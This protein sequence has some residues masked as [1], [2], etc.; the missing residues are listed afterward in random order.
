MPD[1][2]I[3]AILKVSEKAFLFRLI[4]RSCDICRP[5]CQPFYSDFVTVLLTPLAPDFD[6]IC[7]ETLA[8]SAVLWP[9]VYEAYNGS[10]PLR[11]VD[12][13]RKCSIGL[14]SPDRDLIVFATH[15]GDIL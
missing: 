7:I 1:S 3:D 9:Q 14:N 4:V 15:T 6:N 8:R 5:T 11:T 2:K 13:T 10:Q 12:P